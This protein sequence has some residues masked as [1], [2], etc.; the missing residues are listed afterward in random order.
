MGAISVKA[1]SIAELEAHLAKAR[2]ADRPYV[3]VIDTDPYPSTEFGGTWWDVGV[4]EVSGRESVL[5]ARTSWDAGRE[6]QDRT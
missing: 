6:D 5:A 1:G 4:P 3:I 2:Q